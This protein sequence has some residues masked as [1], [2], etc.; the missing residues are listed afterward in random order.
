MKLHHCNHMHAATIIEHDYPEEYGDIMEVLESADVPLRGYSDFSTSG[1]PLKPKRQNKTFQG[2]KKPA[3]MPADLPTL[4]KELDLTLRKRGWTGQPIASTK[5]MEE[6]AKK[7]GLKGDFVKNKIFVEVEFGNTASFHRDLLK[8]HMANRFGVGDVGV[9]VTA[10]DS[11]ARFHDQNVTTF[12][13]ADRMRP[14]LSVGI[15]MPIWIIGIEPTDWSE[16]QARYE[17]MFATCKDNG[18]DCHPY[19]SAAK[20]PVENPPVEEDM[21]V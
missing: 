3:L 6:T 5:E 17:A 1:R 10:M 15:Q 7:M 16:L 13:L 20:V 2:L 19:S 14:Y 8:L 9:I 4:N 12:E 21:E 11:L 18:V